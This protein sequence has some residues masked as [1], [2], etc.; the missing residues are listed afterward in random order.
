MV[1]TRCDLVGPEIDIT[2]Q[3]FVAVRVDRKVSGTAPKDRVSAVDKMA[4]IPVALDRCVTT[5]R[6]NRLGEKWKR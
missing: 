5:V 2:V 6:R 4:G 3:G 1:G